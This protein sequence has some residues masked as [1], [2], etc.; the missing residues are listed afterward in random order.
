VG[1]F[2]SAS[3]ER[4]K[5][6]YALRLEKAAAKAHEAGFD[7]FSTTLL[8]SPYQDFEQ[9]TATGR[10]LADKYDILFYEKDFRPYFRD[11]LTLA[12]E[13]RLYRQKYCGCLFSKEERDQAIKAKECLRG[14]REG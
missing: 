5:A 13:L 3:P 7:A 2:F 1:G 8:I 6:C 11:A 12:K 9:I 4:C 14:K 10:G